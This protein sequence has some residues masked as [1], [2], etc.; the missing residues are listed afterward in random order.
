MILACGK[1]KEYICEDTIE[2]LKVNLLLIEKFVRIIDS[3]K[4]GK[5]TPDE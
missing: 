5:G 2:F 4:Y 1:K 3:I